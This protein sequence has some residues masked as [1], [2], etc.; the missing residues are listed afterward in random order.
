[1]SII[2]LV[3]VNVDDRVLIDFHARINLRICGYIMQMEETY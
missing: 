1:M 3:D 2:S